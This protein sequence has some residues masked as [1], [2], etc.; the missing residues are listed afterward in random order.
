MWA[1]PSSSDC[2][3]YT[4]TMMY[5]TTQCNT[6]IYYTRI[7]EGQSQSAGFLLTMGATGFVRKQ[8][9]F[10]ETST[11]LLWVIHKQSLYVKLSDR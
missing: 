11:M 3:C 2:F 6:M 8:K 9:L 1:W 4:Y 7:K 5:N 10:S